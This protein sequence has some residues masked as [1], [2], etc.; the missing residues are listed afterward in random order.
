MA[1]PITRLA[2]KVFY[3]RLGIFLSANVLWLLL[4]LPLVTLPAATGALFFLTERVIAEERDKDPHIA[5]LADFWLGFR[6]FWRRSTALALLDLAALIVVVFS[7]FFYWRSE[8]ELLHWMIGPTSLIF[9]LLLAMQLYLYPLMLA[10]PQANS[11]QIFVAAF[12]E[13]VARPMD[14]YLVLC[15]LFILAVVCTTLGGP[16]LLV[17]FSLIA[18]VQMINLRAARIARGEIPP[19]EIDQESRETTYR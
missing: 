5:T 9:L 16:I 3:S 19:D 6:L 15:W 18:V 12:W 17:L 8:I 11:Q 2:F 13:V 7:F 1:W 4:S 10:R 14:S